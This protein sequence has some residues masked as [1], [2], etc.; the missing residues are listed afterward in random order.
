MTVTYTETRRSRAFAWQG[1]NPGYPGLFT[2][3]A[4]EIKIHSES[5]RGEKAGF[6]G[7]LNNGSMPGFFV[8]ESSEA[9]A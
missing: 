1:R 2:L 4:Q 3:Q 8:P 7:F 9:I 6:A 5:K